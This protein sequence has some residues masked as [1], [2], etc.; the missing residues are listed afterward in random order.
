[1]ATQLLLIRGLRARINQ[2]TAFNGNIRA[3]HGSI[4][5]NTRSRQVINK[6]NLSG[7]CTQ[8]KSFSFLRLTKL[9]KVDIVLFTQK[10]WYHWLTKTWNS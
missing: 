2:F 8:E 5:Q 3:Q 9:A 10:R 7:W 4:K 6:I 1:M